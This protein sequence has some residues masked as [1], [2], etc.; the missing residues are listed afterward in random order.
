[1][2]SYRECVLSFF[3]L[4]L[5]TLDIEKFL[6]STASSAAPQIPLCRRMLGSNPAL[7]RLRHWSKNKFYLKGWLCEAR[8]APVGR[9]GGGWRDDNLAHLVRLAD[10]GALHDEDDGAGQ[11]L[12]QSWK[13]P[14]FFL[15]QPSWF[16][17]VFLCICPEERVFRVFSVSRILLGASRL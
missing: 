4:D 6:K 11:D 16:F 8:Q 1:M 9:G 15:T 3:D 17:W 2:R 12:T 7:L 5:Y 14:G 10:D 13:K